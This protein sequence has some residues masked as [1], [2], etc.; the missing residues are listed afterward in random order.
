MKNFILFLL[1]ILCLFSCQNDESNEQAQ[2]VESIQAPELIYEFPKD[3]FIVVE[4]KIKRNEVLSTILYRHHV[5][6]PEIDKAVKSCDGIFNVNGIQVD[7]PYTVLCKNDSTEK[8]EYLIYETTKTDYVVMDLQKFETYTAQKEQDI[9]SHLAQGTIESSL[10]LT[11]TDNSLSPA[12]AMEM[13][14]IYAWTIDF[15]RLQKGDH[16]KVFYDRRYVEDE[17]VGIGNIHACEF[18][19][20]GEKLVAYRFENEG[21]VDFYD[22]NGNSLRKAFLKSPLKFGRISSRYTK[23][24]FHPVQKRWKAHKGTDYAAPKG[25]PILSTGDG[26]VIASTYTKNNGNYV[27]IRHNSTYTTQYLHMSKRLVKK[28]EFVK[29]GQTI[30]KVGATGLA[31]G[32]HVCYRFWKNGSQVN[33]LREKFPSAKP[34]DASLM[35]EFQNHVDSINQVMSGATAVLVEN[36]KEPLSKQF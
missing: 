18:L 27:K 21:K 30:G 4:D 32:P 11:M 25:T 23:R 12:L 7:K 10:F 29:Q 20:N 3:S 19:H 35:A 1:P 36:K 34:L 28:G 22:E 33:H 15:Y 13:A 2:V 9:E 31:T 6:W 5:D 14:D 26:T 17:F 24:R 16:F 8:A